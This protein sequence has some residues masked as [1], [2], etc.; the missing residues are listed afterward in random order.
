MAEAAATEASRIRAAQAAL[1]NAG[2]RTEAHPEM[3][4]R[5]EVFEDI[6]RLVC[7]IMPVR[8][9]VFRAVAPVLKTNSSA[10]PIQTNNSRDA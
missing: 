7:A 6:D 3:I 4:R 2:H 8:D 10:D 1:I 9:E 5:A